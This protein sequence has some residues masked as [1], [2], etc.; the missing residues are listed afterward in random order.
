M[1]TSIAAYSIVGE[2]VEKSLEPLPAKPMTDGEIPLWKFTSALVP[3]IPADWHGVRSSRQRQIILLRNWLIHYFPSWG[4]VITL[5]RL[6]PLAA[7]LGIGVAVIVSSRVNDIGGAN[8]IAGL[9]WILFISIFIAGAIGII[10]LNIESTLLIAFIVLV[11][12][13]ALFFL[14]RETFNREEITTKWGLR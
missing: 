1:P 7:V 14:N 12:D 11:A 6:A 8:Q 2:K 4:A 5:F 9:M 13:L 3:P 10:T